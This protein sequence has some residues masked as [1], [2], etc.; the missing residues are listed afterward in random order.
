M[1]STISIAEAHA[2]GELVEK[3]LRGRLAGLERVVIRVEP[4]E[5]SP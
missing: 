1:P 3:D 5:G 4:W 2:T